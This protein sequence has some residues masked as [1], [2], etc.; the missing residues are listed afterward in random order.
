MKYLAKRKPNLSFV[1]L[2][3]NQDSSLV[4]S[5]FRNRVCSFCFSK[6]VKIQTHS[7]LLMSESSLKSS[8]FSLTSFCTLPIWWSTSYFLICEICIV[9][10]KYFSICLLLTITSLKT[11]WDREMTVLHSILFRSGREK[12][13]EYEWFSIGIFT[14][15]KMRIILI[16]KFNKMPIF[17]EK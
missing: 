2:K 11:C 10:L 4:M 8:V 6:S 12:F 13:D 9:H 14:T 5:F 15:C 1:F 17:K 16:K 7:V 3:R